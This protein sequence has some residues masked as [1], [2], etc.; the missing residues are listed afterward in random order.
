MKR[1]VSPVVLAMALV[2]GLIVVPARATTPVAQQGFQAVTPW[3]ILDTRVDSFPFSADETRRLNLDDHAPVGA[4][5]VALNITGVDA[6]VPTFISAWP[7]G[8]RRPLTSVVNVGPGSV[9]SN[10]A[11]LEL[12]DVRTVDLYNHDGSTHVVVDVV[13]WFT[14]D[15]VG[16]T[17][18]RAVDSRW[19][20][21]I[22]SLAGGASRAL[23][24]NGL[25]SLP[26]EAAAVA[27]NATFIAGAA[28]T[29][30]AL[31]PTGQESPTSQ[32]IDLAPGQVI[33]QAMVVGVV[34]GSLTVTVGDG[35]ADVILDVTGWFRGGG[36]FAIAPPTR[37][38]ETKAKKCGATI[39]PNETRTIRLTEAADV[40]AATISIRA[41]GATE[42]TFMTA[43]PTGAPRPETSNINLMPGAVSANL[44]VLEVGPAGQIDIY[45]NSGS[46]EITVDVVGTFKGT[47]PPGE[48]KPCPAPPRPAPR[49]QSPATTAPPTTAAPASA[50]WQADMLAAVNKVRTDRG[51]VPLALCGTL[52]TSAQNYANVLVTTGNISHTGPDGSDLRQ[53]IQAAG[54]L[55]W[56]TIGENLAAGQG[57]VAAVMKAWIESSSHLANLIKP[58]YR[59]VGFGRQMGTYLNS[60]TQSWFWVQHFGANGTC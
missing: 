45:N 1:F 36:T 29:K 43:W 24:L 33:T 58:E 55:G 37:V 15:F 13:G 56:T 8:E 52:N 6:T 7:S 22:T 38:V 25:V 27:V 40:R 23:P 53:R 20:Y 39:G 2:S 41:E 49:P 48:A 51:L 59:H 50:S 31:G 16:M 18:V 44:L 34:N 28:A 11:L 54:Y 47:T 12:S 14:G 32:Q 57:S 19:G 42:Q 46:V 17:P 3:R 26:P 10:L 35:P 60:T 21:G 9:L 5:G 30:V 4:T